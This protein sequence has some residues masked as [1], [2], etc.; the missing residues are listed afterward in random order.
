MFLKERFEDLVNRLT[1]GEQMQYVL[2]GTLILI[3]L[4]SLFSVIMNLTGGGEHG[5][6]PSERHFYCLETEK[7][8]VLT[9]EQMRES[10]D[11]MMGGGIG[12]M[13]LMR[14]ISPYTNERTGVP[15]TRCPN[16]KKWFLPEYL[17]YEPEDE[18][19]YYMM[20]SHDLICTHCGTDVIQWW[21][22]HRKKRK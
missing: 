8:F 15:M 2:S 11:D 12:P 13:G 10:G 5:G 4:I 14:V 17:R 16:C 20:D 6:P 9:P 7:E 18:D 21:R 19:A 3:I 22:E 1:T